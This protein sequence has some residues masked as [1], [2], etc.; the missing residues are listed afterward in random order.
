MVND[1]LIGGPM[2]VS[3]DDLTLQA[4][5][6]TIENELS[7]NSRENLNAGQEVYFYSIQDGQ[8]LG[9]VKNES[10]RSFGCTNVFVEK[11]GTG[12]FNLYQGTKDGVHKVADKVV[13]VEAALI[14]K[15]QTKVTLYFTNEQLAALEQATGKSRT[16]FGVYHVNAAGYTGA[17]SQNTKRYIAVYTPIAGVGA[18]YT[19]TNPE[20]VNG[21]YALGTTVSTLGTTTQ[22]ESA[23]QLPEQAVANSWKFSGVYPNPGNGVATVNVTIPTAT[24]MT[25]DIVNVS[26]Q[27]LSTRTEQVVEGLRTINLPVDRLSRGAYLIRF[28]DAEGNVLNTQ[29]Y[30]RN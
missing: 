16:Q 30:T 10:T 6:R 1:P 2:S 15:A 23:S 9:N 22:M 20:K 29:H 26:G 19:I 17:S 4:S 27:V 21:S 8:L 11:A 18:S 7:H 3:V 28:R 13:R 12:T 14:F 5:A 24:R 25:I